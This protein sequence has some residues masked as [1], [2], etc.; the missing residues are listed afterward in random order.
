[1]AKMESM[2]G[3]GYIC[4]PCESRPVDLQCEQGLC[5]GTLSAGGERAHCGRLVTLPVDAAAKTSLSYFPH[6]DLPLALDAGAS[7][8]ARDA[9]VQKTVFGCD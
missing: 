2:A 1:M 8:A 6:A 5:V 3:Y 9:S 4:L 7:D